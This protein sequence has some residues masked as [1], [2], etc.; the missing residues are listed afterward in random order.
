M[1]KSNVSKN[2][3]LQP[4]KL[5]HLTFKNRI[6]S[7][8]HAPNYVNDSLPK[9][10][11]QAYHKEKAK[12]GI[13][14][15][16]FGGSSNVSID[17]PSVFGQIDI[18]NDKV[19]P[20]L[21]EFSETIHSYNC[22]LMCQITHMGRR[23]PYNV[24]NWTI[25][26]APSNIREHSHRSFPKEL[27]HFEIDRIINDFSKAAYRCKLSGLDGVEI[28]A[29]AHLIDSFWSPLTNKRTDKYGGT[30]QCCSELQS[31]FHVW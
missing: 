27:D 3:L 29:S 18:S 14:M 26:L 19:I 20:Y 24:G 13:A 5:R 23:Q 8:A 28:M 9:S 17:S 22:K 25:P 2:P 15:T 10:K 30:F 4:F 1:T 31:F 16:M 7:T 21:Q 12:G 11:Y 6:L